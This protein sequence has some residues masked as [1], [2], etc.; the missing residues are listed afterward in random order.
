MTIDTDR[1]NELILA[2]TLRKKLT[3]LTA[4]EKEFVKELRADLRDMKK[5]GIE[6]DI[7]GEMAG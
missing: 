1:M 7:P 4:E 2:V 5:R 3:N 6:V